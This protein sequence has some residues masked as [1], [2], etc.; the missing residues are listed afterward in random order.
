MRVPSNNN[1]GKHLQYSPDSLTTR[2]EVINLEN[3]ACEIL[4]GTPMVCER[5]EN[6]ML[7]FGWLFLPDR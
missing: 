3:V 6:G 5:L 2:D 7:C 4:L 1:L